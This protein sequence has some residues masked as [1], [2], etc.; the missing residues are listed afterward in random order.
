MFILIRTTVIN[1]TGSGS[2]RA[3]PLRIPLR[4][5]RGSSLPGPG[6]KLVVQGHLETIAAF[7]ARKGHASSA[8][9]VIREWA[10]AGA[11]KIIHEA[12]INGTWVTLDDDIK[13]PDAPVAAPEFDVVVEGV[14]GSAELPKTPMK[15][16]EAVAEVAE[17]PEAPAEDDSP[18]AVIVSDEAP[19]MVDVSTATAPDVEPLDEPDAIVELPIE[20]PMEVEEPTMEE[21]EATVEDLVVEE[22]EAP[23]EAPVTIEEPVAEETL[24]IDLGEEDE[25]LEDLEDGLL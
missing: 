3:R 18:I 14:P 7:T 2:E 24:A 25:A 19:E 8:L 6:S 9:R 1:T 5:G 20:E 15:I 16:E 22:P 17:V 13:D 10:D 23:A 12:Q 21:S 4:T 11:I